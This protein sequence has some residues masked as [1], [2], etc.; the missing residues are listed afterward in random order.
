MVELVPSS[1]EATQAAADLMKRF[2]DRTGLTSDAAPQRYLWTDA[3]AVCNFVGLWRATGDAKLLVLA[4]EL[5]D[6][7]HHVLGHYREDDSRKGWLS[8]LVGPQAEA[9]PTVRGLR[10]GKPLPERGRE[11]R[12][13]ERLEWERDGQYFHYLTKWM[14]ALDQL[15][16]AVLEPRFNRWA[17]ELARAAHDGFVVPGPTHRI[18]WKMSTDLTRVLVPAA[19]MHDALDGFITCVQLDE[20]AAKLRRGDGNGSLEDITHHFAAMLGGRDF[21]TADPLGIGGLL[22]DAARVASLMRCGA[23]HDESLLELLLDAARRGLYVYL[24]DA[25]LARDPRGRIA[26]REL[27]LAIGLSAL[28][29]IR[30]DV[31]VTP[32]A[33]RV[34]DELRD[35]ERVQHLAAELTSQWLSF[36]GAREP[37]WQAHRDINDV[38]LA[39]SLAPGGV[40]TLHALTQGASRAVPI[41]TSLQ[42]ERTKNVRHDGV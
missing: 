24:R 10:I 34:Q 14:H 37:S 21:A 41:E 30:D 28:T 18:A 39:S 32:C 38:M 9:H 17:R 26:F 7:V 8:G 42:H 31:A 15:A 23:L 40:C 4:G 27:G 25:E 2:A 19:G 6:Q 29:Q 3:F 12:F 33:A 36:D 22:M 5:V 11:E 16:R 1:A 35:L 13:D 20:T